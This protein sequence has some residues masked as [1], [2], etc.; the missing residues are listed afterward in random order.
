MRKTIF[1]AVRN[2]RGG[3]PFT[4]AEVA[5]LDDCLDRLQVPRDGSPGISSR[6]T[7]GSFGLSSRPSEAA[8][9]SI[10]PKGL[11]IIKR[12]EGLRLEAY[13]C[14]AGVWTIGWGS[15]G[16][17]VRAGLTITEAQAEALLDADLARFEKGVAKLAPTATQEQFDAMVS[18][19]F[20]IGTG[21]LDLEDGDAREEGFTGSSV[22]RHH[23]AGRHAQAA[24]AFGMWVKSKGR[25]LR[26]LVERRAAEASL[27][28]SAGV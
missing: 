4:P 28:R 16:K 10:G 13:R 15:T 24:D 23:R 20:N 12:Y 22:L 7:D 21:D 26:G 18:L 11:A 8:W 27:Y 5:Q 17:H 9:R 2:A 19:A 3:R 14:P 6:Q 1:D 25:T